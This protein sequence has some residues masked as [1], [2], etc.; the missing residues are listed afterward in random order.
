LIGKF[1][2]FYTGKQYAKGYETD[3]ASVSFNEVEKITLSG[4]PDLNLGFEYRYTDRLG[5]YVDINNVVAIRYFKFNNYPTQRLNAMA[6][7]SYSF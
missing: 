7:L 2:L 3:T 5:L 4:F 6:G 1:S